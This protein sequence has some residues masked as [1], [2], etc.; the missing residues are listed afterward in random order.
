M[1]SINLTPNI[2]TSGSGIDVTSVV[3]QILNAE[4]ATERVWQTQQSTLSTQSAALK[5]ISGLLVDLQTKV[6]AL[7]DISG[8][9]STKTV[10]SSSPSILTA[11]AQSSAVPG[12]HVIRVANL[13]STSSYYTDAIPNNTTLSPGSFDLQV[14]SGTPA[15]VT[16]GAGNNTLAT[17]AVSINNANLGV[18]ASVVNDVSG[19]HLALISNTLGAPGDL[20]I[21]NNTTSLGF[22][23]GANGA[24]ALLT[25]DGIPVG[26]ASNTVTG[27]LPGVTLNL[28]G[29]SAGTDVQVNVSQDTTRAGQAV[30]SFVSSYNNLISAVNT[31]FSFNTTNNTAGPLAGDSFLRSLQSSLLSDVTYSISGNNGYVNLASLGVNMNNDGTLSV[32]ADQLNDVL[33]NHF[34]DFQNFFQS[35][36]PDK[37]FG[38]NFSNDLRALNDSTNGAVSLDL[39]QIAATQTLLTNQIRDFEDRLAVRQKFLINQYSQ[40]DAMLRQFPLIMQ[41]LN[42]QLATLATSS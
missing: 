40:V 26:S 30:Q 22:N 23:K 24:N 20:T 29:A 31:Q 3:N 8:E 2:V 7:S 6:N 33:A 41:Q 34:S 42:S 9:L 10:T 11:S 5:S 25:V 15:T 17:L 18:S 27:V 19:S 28:A 38:V 39:S 35:L 1:S 37:G 14:G 32:D 21:S 13:A 12:N 16:I 36:A 4:R